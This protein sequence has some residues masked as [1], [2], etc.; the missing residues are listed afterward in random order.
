MTD[1]I[2]AADKIKCRQVAEAILDE[3]CSLRARGRK[4]EAITWTMIR[5]EAYVVYRDESRAEQSKGE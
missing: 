1:I 4:E 3:A 2:S 5:M